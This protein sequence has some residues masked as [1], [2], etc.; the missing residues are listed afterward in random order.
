MLNFRKVLLVLILLASGCSMR[1]EP[2]LAA[3]YAPVAAQPKSHP[4]IVIPGIMGSRLYRADTNHE[5]WPG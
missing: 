1:H 2:D 5:I 4:L 3:L